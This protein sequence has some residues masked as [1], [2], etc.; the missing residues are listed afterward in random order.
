MSTPRDAT[1]IPYLKTIWILQHEEHVR[2]GVTVLTERLAKAPA[3]VSQTVR[4]LTQARLIHHEPYGP[5]GLT[6]KGEQ[7]ALAVV[8]HNRIARAFLHRVLGIPWT[9]VATEADA[10][11][12]VLHDDLA[13]RLHKVSGSPLTDPYGNPIPGTGASTVQRAR[14]LSEQPINTELEILRV[15]DTDPALL[16]RLEALELTPGRIVRVERMDHATEVIDVN[17]NNLEHTIGVQA[18]RR[19]LVARPDETRILFQDKGSTQTASEAARPSVSRSVR[20]STRTSTAS[21]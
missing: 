19:I 14:P 4:S 5:I 11:M 21:E 12:P 1:I 16:G 13:N 20:P 17:C 7:L 18:A 10:L 9:D 2:V 3:T 15:A 8:R 6:L